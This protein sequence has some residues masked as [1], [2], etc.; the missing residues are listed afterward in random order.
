MSST[1]AT[2]EY[3]KS[4]EVNNLEQLSP[5]PLSNLN[6]LCLSIVTADPP[7]PPPYQNRLFLWSLQ[8]MPLPDGRTTPGLLEVASLTF[9]WLAGSATQAPSSGNPRVLPRVSAVG[10]YDTQGAGGAPTELQAVAR[11]AGGTLA[12]ITARLHR[13]S[14]RG[15]FTFRNTRSVV[16]PLGLTGRPRFSQVGGQAGTNGAA[17][18]K[19]AVAA[20]GEAGW[21]DADGVP[22]A[23]L[24]LIARVRRSGAGAAG[25]GG[26]GW[27]VEVHSWVNGGSHLQ[28]IPCKPRGHGRGE[29]GHTAGAEPGHADEEDGGGGKLGDSWLSSDS[30]GNN[31]VGLGSVAPLFGELASKVKSGDELSF[32]PYALPEVTVGCSSCGARSSR[33][34]SD[35]RVDEDAESMSMGDGACQCEDG[36]ECNGGG[37]RIAHAMWL[38]DWV[39]AEALPPALAVID[40]NSRLH[41]FELDD[42]AVAEE[43]PEDRFEVADGM[44]AIGLA[45]RHFLGGGA[46]GSM[47]GTLS[48]SMKNLSLKGIGGT[49]LEDYRERSGDRPSR[50]A[51]ADASQRLVLDD[52]LPPREKTVV[53]PLDA[54]Y[55][56]GLTLAFQ[57]NQVKNIQ[58]GF[59]LVLCTGRTANRRCLFSFETRVLTARGA[60]LHV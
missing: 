29:P 56:L 14:A 3:M 36:G 5:P 38:A 33:G 41:V 15:K 32:V 57:D 52:G 35:V 8:D 4:L 2:T 1:S 10:Y 53:L 50:R 9:R 43:A 37:G 31:S 17:G 48:H 22:H 27:K 40:G 45:R 26:G 6:D 24:P 46:A 42:G 49:R 23:N 19:K 39:G 54:K 16:L 47:M 12:V 18:A 60:S 44:P 28:C 25:S 51:Q 13:E 34:R 59:D 55:G 11:A 7:Q 58:N 21:E 20:A 30:T